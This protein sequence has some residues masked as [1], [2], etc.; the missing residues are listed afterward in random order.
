MRR[1]CWAL[2]ALAGCTFGQSD[3]ADSVASVGATDSPMMGTTAAGDDT[4]GITTANPSTS[5]TKLPGTTDDDGQITAT[6][7]ETATDDGTTSSG[8]GTTGAADESTS[9]GGEEPELTDDGVVVRYFLDDYRRGAPPNGGTAKDAG[10]MPVL[11]LPFVMQGGQPAYDASSGNS[12]LTWTNASNNGRAIAPVIDTKIMD[13][14]GLTEFTLEI[15]VDIE[16]ANGAGTRYIHIGTSN[17]HSIALVSDNPQSMHLRTHA[18]N[19]TA[20]WDPDLTNGRTVCTVVV[21]L[22]LMGADRYRLFLNGSEEVD[23]TSS[24][25]LE[26]VQ[27]DAG[28]SIS[29]GNRTDGDRAMVGTL[30]YAAIYDRAL[31]PDEVQQNADALGNSD[32]SQ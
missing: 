27:I 4:T 8:D 14:D 22:S 30:F 16:A 9:T 11:D 19:G 21:D 24:Q 31:S 26:M 25:N 17:D 15:V 6:A 2:L 13:L 20:F 3:L 29:L 5:G 10:P 23:A 28:H 1:G 32:D 18:S 12:G 7:T